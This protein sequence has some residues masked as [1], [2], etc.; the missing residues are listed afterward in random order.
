M[1]LG[2]TDM[3]YKYTVPD[4]CISFENFGIETNLVKCVLRLTMLHCILD[5]W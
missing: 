1:I 3:H 4:L 2:S 5:F